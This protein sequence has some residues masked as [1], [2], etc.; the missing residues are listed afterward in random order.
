MQLRMLA[1][2]ARAALDDRA[3]RP[4]AGDRARVTALLG[5][6]ARCTSGRPP[7][8]EYAELTIGYRLPGAILDLANRLL[9][10]AAAD[11]AP[12]RSVRDDRRP[13]GR[14]PLR[15]RR[16]RRRGRRA[17][18]GA[19]RRRWRRSRSSP[20]THASTA[21]RGCARGARRRARRA[22]ARCRPI[23]RSSSCPAAL[24]KGLEFDA[25]DR[26]RAGRDRRA[27]AARGPAAV[28]RADASG[29]APRDR[30]QSR[31]PAVLGSGM[32]TAGR[33]EPA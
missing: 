7:N 27:R 32:V 33:R 15:R 19:R 11:V 5:R 12:S 26:R 1:R 23:I 17:R 18:A 14:P 4:R 31:L 22:R 2:R 28:R 8:A 20:T 6:N 25:V 10:F 16:A 3:R 29:A 9:P 24:A 21:L 13:A 30:A